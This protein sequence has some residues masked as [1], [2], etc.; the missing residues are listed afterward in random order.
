MPLDEHLEELDG[1]ARRSESIDLALLLEQAARLAVRH[2]TKQERKSDGY[3]EGQDTVAYALQTKGYS[4]KVKDVTDWWSYSDCSY[5]VSSGKSTTRTL[6]LIKNG[7]RL[8]TATQDLGGTSSDC[9]RG[10]ESAPPK[11]WRHGACTAG[12]AEA[13][14]DAIQQLHSKYG[15]QA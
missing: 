13:L 8:I 9:C 10:K 1:R 11:P 15:R 12:Q 14:T 5:S 4:V 2:G 6:H 3:K 7:K